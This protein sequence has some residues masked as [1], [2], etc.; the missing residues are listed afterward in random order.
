MGPMAASANNHVGR[1]WHALSFT[2]MTKAKRAW[3]ITE[4][5]V[6]VRLR[7]RV[8]VRGPFG[9]SGRYSKIL[10]DESL[11]KIRWLVVTACAWATA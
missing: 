3:H 9:A 11:Y 2:R 8:H 1:G 7:L 5:C 4:L 10:Q 6:R